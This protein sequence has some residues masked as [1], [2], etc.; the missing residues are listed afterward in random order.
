[1][2]PVPIL[3][4]D[5]RLVVV[6][7]PAGLATH[8]GWAPEPDVLVARLRAQLGRPVL[9]AH[10]LD[11]GTSGVLVLALDSDTARALGAA[12]TAGGVQKTY[13]TLVRGVPAE[14]GTIDHPLR[15]GDDRD[16]PRV[17]ARTDFTRRE[18]LG[19]YSLVEARPLTGRLHQ[20]RRHMKHIAC[21][22]VGDV[23]Y[24]KGEHNRL[25]RDRLGLR[26]MFLH[27]MTLRLAHPATGLP[28]EL[29]APLPDELTAALAGLR[30]QLADGT[31]PIG[32]P[33]AEPPSQAAPST[34]LGA[35]PS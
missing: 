19:R 24:G 29:H 1:V 21:H 7:K 15:G 28:L 33:G 10:R 30:R 27:A 2:Q 25:F 18:I 6:D 16:G 32:G 8:R 14:E 9:A 26:R 3:F 23:K 35:A 22:V 17:P 34:R 4:Q 20:I 31:W 5:E 12:F 11:R 13:V